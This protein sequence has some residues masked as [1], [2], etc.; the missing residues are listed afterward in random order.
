MNQLPAPNQLP[1][2]LG[3]TNAQ[4]M[5]VIYVISNLAPFLLRPTREI[6]ETQPDM[7]TAVV[8]SAATTFV[9]ACA[10]LDTILDDKKR[11]D[12]L[13]TDSL[14]A[15]LTKVYDEEAKRIAEH[16]TALQNLRRPSM[17]L[18]PSLTFDQI[19]RMWVARHG[20]GVNALH[21]TGRTPR[22]AMFNFDLRFFDIT[23][24]Q[25]PAE[26]DEDEQQS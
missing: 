3:V 18:K 15:A 1:S 26:P 11:W 17:I 8:D 24:Q 19:G 13:T 12:T 10:V 14:E 5:N 20:E 23:N 4:L 9:K 21:A 16:R 6:T 22:E 2:N 25:P 7:D